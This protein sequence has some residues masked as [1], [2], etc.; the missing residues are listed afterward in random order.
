MTSDIKLP[1]QPFIPHSL[2]FSVIIQFPF[3]ENF[4]EQG[5]SNYIKLPPFL[6]FLACKSLLLMI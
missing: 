2:G 5:L 6:L 4:S 3:L 1:L